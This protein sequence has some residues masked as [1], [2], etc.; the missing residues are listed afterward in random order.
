MEFYKRK[1][2]MEKLKGYCHLS[3]EH[4]FMEV[5]E[6]TNGEGLDICVNDEKYFSLTHGEL[7]LLSVLANIDRG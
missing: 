2:V 1:A 5:T 3:K 6:W 7:Q 4:A